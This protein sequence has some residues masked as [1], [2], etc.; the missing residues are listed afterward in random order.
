MQDAQ[1]DAMDDRV[2]PEAPVF[3]RPEVMLIPGRSDEARASAGQRF[4]RELAALRDE[5]AMQVRRV[6]AGVRR[7]LAHR[8][9]IRCDAEP[10]Q[11]RLVPHFD[12]LDEGAGGELAGSRRADTAAVDPRT[13]RIRD[14]G[15]EVPLRLA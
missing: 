7:E 10:Q 12:R 3:G 2:R 5:E 11:V 14:P 9:W 13:D 1:V 8:R 15:A 4:E 6:D